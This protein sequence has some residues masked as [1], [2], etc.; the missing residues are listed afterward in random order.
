MKTRKIT[1]IV[2]VL[3][4]IVVFL[5]AMYARYRVGEVRS[6]VESSSK[7]FSNNPVDTTIKKALNEKIS[8]YDMPIMLAMI[9]GIVLVVIGV[10]VYAYPRKKR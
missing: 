2:L 7:F 5:M 8:S 6:S 1:S 3:L 9:G 4:G 10:G